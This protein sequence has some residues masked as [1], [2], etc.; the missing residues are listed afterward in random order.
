MPQH[1]DIATTE[2]NFNIK[3]TLHSNRLRGLW[4]LMKGFR[5]HYL[6]ATIA[7]ALAALLN[8]ASLLLLRHLVD[9]ILVEPSGNLVPALLS[10]AGLFIL[11][12]LLRGVFSFFSGVLTAETAE[13]IALRI[14][15][16]MFDHI[17]NLVFA[18]HDRMKTGE[19][20]QRVTSDIDAIRRFYAEQAIEIGRVTILFSVN[21]IA[22]L[23]LHWQLALFSVIVVPLVVIISLFFFRRVSVAYDAFQ[24]QDGV[25]SARL[26]ENLSGVRVVKAFARQS[27]ER[28]N[29]EKEN[30][31]KFDLG[32][33]FMQMHATYWPVVD[34]MTG[35]QT[36]AGLFVG[37][38]LAI[39][40]DITP[41]T[42]ISYAAMLSWIINPMRNLGRVIVQMSTGLVS[43][44]RIAEVIH[45]DW[46][47]LGR[48]RKPPV[49][50][51]S[52]HIVFSNVSFAY[53]TGARIL[54]DLS[55]EVKPG[56]TVAL[57]GS[58]GSGKTS[59]ISLLT[60]FYDYSEGSITIDGVELRDY[61]R[62]FL[63]A[64]I[65]IVEQEPFL[66]SR[67]IRENITYGVAREV[68]DE[69]VI[70]ATKAA[71]VHDVIESF[72]EK[73]RT[74]VGERGVTLSGGQKQR[75]ALSRTLLKNPR[76]LVLDDATSSVDTQTES[77]IREAL[78]GLMKSRTSF[79]IAHR[80]QSVMDA[81]LIL[82]MDQGRIVQRGT[83]EQLMAEAGVYR[84][85]YDMQARIETELESELSS[86]GL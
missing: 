44:D 22:L 52:G 42:Y 38:L 53:E 65:G 69:E 56:Q 46:E 16:Y 70:T 28:S 67:S 41:G 79:I 15:D 59:L 24:E 61:P 27:H 64:S 82:V 50:D 77:E 25:L 51:I 57:M 30:T 58:T 63:R 55:F 85:T 3:S 54:R 71:A 26:Q 48:D 5:R 66:F 37:A 4:Q 8:T 84:R 62:H 60:R 21:F 20:V 80:I 35:F 33:R 83:H 47:D 72:P 78:N 9:N 11:L 19:L 13:G 10:V 17:Q 7:L 36:I 29:F 81:D 43:Y 1:A 14:K 31:K 49:E 6:G 45:E 34:L 75:I 74:L 39:Q 86:V 40:G 2:T 23:A 12:T 68:S 18:Y 73:Y 76:V 32:I